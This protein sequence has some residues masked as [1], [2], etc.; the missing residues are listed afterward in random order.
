MLRAEADSWGSEAKAPTIATNRR[1]TN[2]V[3]TFLYRFDHIWHLFLEKG[4]EKFLK[5]RSIDD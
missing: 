4:Y 3:L 5:K 2:I 1:Y